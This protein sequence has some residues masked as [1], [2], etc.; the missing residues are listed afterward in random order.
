MIVNI[1]DN[2]SIKNEFKLYD[3]K[4]WFHVINYNFLNIIIKL[5]IYLII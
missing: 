1:Y 4:T 2:N 5:I 3:H